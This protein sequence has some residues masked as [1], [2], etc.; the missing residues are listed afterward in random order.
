[1][2]Q[3]RTSKSAAELQE[4]REAIVEHSGRARLGHALQ[5]RAA[6]PGRARGRS[7]QG[8]TGG[9]RRPSALDGGGH[10][11]QAPPPPTQALFTADQPHSRPHPAV[12]EAQLQ[13]CNPSATC[14]QL[15]QRRI[16]L[17]AYLLSPISAIVWRPPAVLGAWR[18]PLMPGCDENAAIALRSDL[19]RL[20]M[21]AIA[22]QSLGPPGAAP[23]ASRRPAAGCLER[24]GAKWEA[25]Q[26]PGRHGG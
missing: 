17:H 5:R 21:D 16:A 24:G 6:V 11:R 15:G 18:P 3:T 7:R 4:A 25:L 19:T 8:S 9:L 14:S 26:S 23:T 2:S 13:A 12:P 20:Q 1:M 10:V 22:P